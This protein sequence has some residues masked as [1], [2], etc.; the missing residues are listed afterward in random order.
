[1]RLTQAGR[2]YADEA[3]R[4]LE[5]IERAGV[6]AQ[7]AA[8]GEIDRLTI[9]MND[10]G[11]RNR[12]VARCI[13]RFAAMYPEVQ[14]DFLTSVSQDQL[15]AL[16]YGR[17]DAGILIERPEDGSLDHLKVA[18]DPFWIALPV[19]HPLADLESVPVSALAGEPF[20][21]VAM[22]TYWL[23][24]TRLLA[25][26]RVLGLVPRV[27]LEASNDHMQISFITAG[28][29]IG[30]VNASMADRLRGEVVLRPVDELDT[31]SEIDLVWLRSAQSR[32]LANFA[33]TMRLEVDAAD[34]RS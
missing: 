3:R 8:R 16:R 32:S 26:C 1:M 17:I 34:Q 21:S 25:R 29:G 24:Q 6:R 15:T 22:S 28:M 13:A 9:A 11:T 31:V 12:T 18:R 23:P 14:M 20:V 33:S 10:L 19:N 4:S 7:K 30:F 5:L 2:V 27:V